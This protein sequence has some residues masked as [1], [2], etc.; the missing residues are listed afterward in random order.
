MQNLLS[1]PAVGCVIS[2]HGG[3]FHRPRVLV[4]AGAAPSLP[5]AP[6][7]ER[8][9]GY[10]QQPGASLPTCRVTGRRAADAP[11]VAFLLSGRSSGKPDGRAF[12]SP[13]SRWANLPSLSSGPRPAI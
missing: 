5:F 1:Q 12:T 8:S 3:V 7:R 6:M 11:L 10:A 4:G 9:A 13:R 2:G